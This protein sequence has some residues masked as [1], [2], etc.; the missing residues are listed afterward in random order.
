MLD[1]RRKL[2]AGV[3]IGGEEVAMAE[4][5][6]PTG[7]LRLLARDADLERTEGKITGWRSTDGKAR[8]LTAEPNTGNSTL[9]GGAR[10]GLVFRDGV[11]CGF[12][13]PAFAERADC[14]TAAVIYSAGGEARTLVSVTTGQSNN[15]VFLG[16]TR[17]SWVVTD[18]AGTASVSQDRKAGPGTQLAILSY[19]GQT[20][21]LR[22]GG[23]VLSTTAKLPKMDLPGDVFFGCRSNRPGLAKT[24]G[25][26]LLHEAFFWPDRALLSSARGEDTAFLVALDR[27]FRWT[28]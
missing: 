22:A 3:L 28:Y 20:L 27:Y 16:E 11:N 18:K 8:A 5:L 26:M 23:Q 19:S 7:G 21:S 17:G 25:Q 24:Q 2:P 1:L 13:L 9:D 4:A 12:V 6:V 15:L 14:F 10:P